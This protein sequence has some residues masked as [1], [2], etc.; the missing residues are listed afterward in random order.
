MNVPNA[1]AIAGMAD[2]DIVEVGCWI[3]ANGIRPAHIGTI[4]AD[5]LV[6]MQAVKRYE[7]LAAQAILTRD[8]MLAIAALTQHPLIGSYPLAE[9]LIDAFLN[10]HAPLIG[11]WS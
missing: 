10:A 9:R 7:R 6:L 4:P 1:G 2:D 11:D 3:D 5:Q 8:R